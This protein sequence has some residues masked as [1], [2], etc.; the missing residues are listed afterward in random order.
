MTPVVQN[1]LAMAGDSRDEPL[2]PGLARYPGEG[3]DNTL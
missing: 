1:L 3:N 2:V